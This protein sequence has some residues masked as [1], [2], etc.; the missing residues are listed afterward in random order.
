MNV[1]RIPPFGNKTVPELSSRISRGALCVARE[2]KLLLFRG[3]ELICSE[4]RLDVD[5]ILASPTFGQM[6]V[7]LW[8]KTMINARALLPG[9]PLPGSTVNREKFNQSTGSSMTRHDV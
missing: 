5:C 7:V 1:P 3:E 6:R 9:R 2:P 8:E 4:V